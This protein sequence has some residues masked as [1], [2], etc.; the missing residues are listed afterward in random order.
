M[1]RKALMSFAHQVSRRAPHVAG[2]VQPVASPV[3]LQAGQVVGV[4]NLVG[5]YSLSPWHIGQVI[6]AGYRC[7]FGR[8][9]MPARIACLLKEAFMGELMPQNLVTRLRTAFQHVND[10]ACRALE[11]HPATAGSF[12]LHWQMTDLDYRN[13][14]VAPVIAP[15]R[16]IVAPRIRFSPSG[17]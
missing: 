8:S 11:P 6:A 13:G 17:R 10:I 9:I 7:L 5:A 1:P 15:R 16:V 12:R 4:M 3:P 2:H 14:V